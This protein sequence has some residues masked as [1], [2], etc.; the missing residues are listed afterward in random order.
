MGRANLHALRN[1]SGPI[2]PLLEISR[3]WPQS[4]AIGPVLVALGGNDH[5]SF[6]VIGSHVW[7]RLY[8]T[9]YGRQIL[10]E[11]YEMILAE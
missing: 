1:R 3:G 6:P 10:F 4:I 11:I 2:F 7:T 8:S 5:L 9:D